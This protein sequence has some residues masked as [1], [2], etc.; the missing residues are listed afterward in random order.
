MRRITGTAK[1]VAANIMMA[2]SI[3]RNESIS[4]SKNCIIVLIEAGTV[5]L[6]VEMIPS[7]SDDIRAVLRFA[8]TRTPNGSKTPPNASQPLAKFGLPFVFNFSVIII[9]CDLEIKKSCFVDLAY[10]LFQCCVIVD[11]YCY[12]S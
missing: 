8:S 4:L 5:L 10:L 11:F 2:L 6:R 9:I 12:C 3:L 7:G 1:R